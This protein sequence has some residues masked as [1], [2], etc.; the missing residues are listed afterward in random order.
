[1]SHAT[2]DPASAA[3]GDRRQGEFAPAADT[4]WQR[5]GWNRAEEAR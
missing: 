1:M 4:R 2:R 5:G 3:S